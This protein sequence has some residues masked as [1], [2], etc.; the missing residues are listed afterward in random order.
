[1]AKWWRHEGWLLFFYAII[2]L[3]FT[4]YY[5]LIWNG[6][7]GGVMGY[8]SF[9]LDKRPEELHEALVSRL[10][11]M[12]AA[13]LGTAGWIVNAYNARRQSRIGVIMDHVAHTRANEIY[14]YHKY[15]VWARY[16]GSSG[17]VEPEDVPRLRSERKK[18]RPTGRNGFGSIDDV[19]VLESIFHILNFLEGVCGA[20]SDG[21]ADERYFRKIYLDVMS[22][23]FEKFIHIIA[24]GSEGGRNGTFCEIVGMLDKWYLVGHLESPADKAFPEGRRPSERLKS[25]YRDHKQIYQGAEH[26]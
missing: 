12:T 11:L 22:I 8:L 23:S 10:P 4:S 5:F 25:L 6:P 9:H 15:N 3:L 1:M 7:G 2:F 17:K 26:S 18:M 13:F 20:I 16:P 14:Q 21:K 24:A 19:P